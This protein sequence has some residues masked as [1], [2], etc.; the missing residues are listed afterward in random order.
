MTTAHKV[1]ITDAGP[2]RKRVSIS[3]PADVVSARLRK[4]VDS[5]VADAQLPGFRRGRAPRHLVEKKF[6]SALRDDAKRALVAEAVQSAVQEHKLKV[7]GD[8]TAELENVEVRDGQDLSFD[9][10]VEVMPEF[11][12][13]K[14]E[15]LEILKPTFEIPDSMIDDEVK[16]FQ[17]NEGRLESRDV[18]EP[19][20][21]LTGHG[22]MKGADGTEFYNIKGAVVQVPPADKGGK[23]MILGVMVDD[24][25]TQLGVPKAGDS[26][27][28][29]A[30]GP[31]SHEVEA[32]RGAKLTITFQVE[33]C[34]RII[35]ADLSEIVSRYGFV[36]EDA[37]R[38]AVKSRLEQRG[39]VQ[40]SAAMRQQ[41]ARY[42]L[43][44]TQMELPQRLS[45]QQAA[46]TLQR[47]RLELMYRGHE[48]TQIEE[49]MAELRANSAALAQGELKL[50][51]LLSKAGDQLN[52]QV[53]EAE[54][55]G[56]IAQIAA[57][58]NIRPEMLRQELINRNQ[59]G[60]IFQ[61][62]REHKTFDAIIAKANIKDV[63]ADEFN[64]KIAEESKTAKNAGKRDS[65]DDKAD[66]GEAKSESKPK[67]K[68]KKKSE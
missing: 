63:S 49:H 38:E 30:T 13:P 15:G 7:V 8:A 4:G 22:I 44:N 12:L 35:P 66:E 53:N 58:R 19:G 20:D 1:S 28:I 9:V 32:I 55:N 3:I 50:F 21:Y 68:G 51:F 14:L 26:V 5:V 52:I 11:E 27:T 24:F 34:D 43:D 54:M 56:R 23:G 64:K 67:S 46:R 31:E 16:K 17:I 18:P 40:Q 57:E 25:S 60:G 65:D 6:G 37:L 39:L 10:D 2:S 48:A 36:S 59:V 33:R 47:Q 41:V 42:L 45:A 29:R 61:Q 62:L